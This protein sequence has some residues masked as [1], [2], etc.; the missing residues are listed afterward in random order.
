[1]HDAGTSACC[2]QIPV[3]FKAVCLEEHQGE[4]HV[5]MDTPLDPQPLVWKFPLQAS[6]D[7]NFTLYA[8]QRMMPSCISGGNQAWM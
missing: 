4:V 7:C 1:M 3:T 5:I 6:Y 2:L 8:L